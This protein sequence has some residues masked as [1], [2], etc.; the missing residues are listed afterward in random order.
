MKLLGHPRGSV[1]RFKL[2]TYEQQM[3][4]MI[5][6]QSMGIYPFEGMDANEK[7]AFHKSAENYS[8]CNG[9]L[10]VKCILKKNDI[11]PNEG[12]FSISILIIINFKKLKKKPRKFITHTN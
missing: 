6:Y 3:M 8:Y 11:G 2:L 4:K 7:G 5:N 10:K 9:L 12:K 1:S